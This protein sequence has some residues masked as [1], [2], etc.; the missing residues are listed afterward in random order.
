MRTAAGTG[1]Q[2]E[3]AVKGIQ[4]STKAA[5][6]R[7]TG[8]RSAR[9][10]VRSRDCSA[11]NK[12]KHAIQATMRPL[13]VQSPICLMGRMSDTASA[14]NPTAVANMDAVQGRNLLASARA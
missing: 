11:G 5:Y 13:A 3:R 7:P 14:A 8:A 2:G 1:G 4:T 9:V 6:Q 12:V 10:G